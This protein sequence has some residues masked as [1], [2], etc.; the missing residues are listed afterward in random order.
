M[1]QTC[2]LVIAMMVG[3]WANGEVVQVGRSDCLKLI[4][5]SRPECITDLKEATPCVP[6]LLFE[7]KRWLAVEQHTDGTLTFC[8]CVTPHEDLEVFTV[9]ARTRGSASIHWFVISSDTSLAA[10]QASAEGEFVPAFKGVVLIAPRQRAR[11]DGSLV[12]GLKAFLA[13]I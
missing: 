7:G 1:K 9:A 6:G 2:V 11:T 10:Q 13:G 5:Q 3:N 4:Q 12:S 8:H